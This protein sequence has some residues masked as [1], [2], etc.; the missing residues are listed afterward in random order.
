MKRLETSRMNKNERS[1]SCMSSRKR[2]LTMDENGVE[3]LDVFCPVFPNILECLQSS[4]KSLV[5][6]SET[7]RWLSRCFWALRV[8]WLHQQVCSSG[9]SDP[10]I[11]LIYL[12]T[13]RARVM[14]AR[15]FP[16]S[17]NDY[18]PHA[19]LFL[20][21]P[22][23]SHIFAIFS[24]VYTVTRWLLGCW[25]RPP[26]FS[27]QILKIR[28]LR[29]NGRVSSAQTSS[30]QDD[31]FL[32]YSLVIYISGFSQVRTA[33]THGCSVAGLEPAFLL[34]YSKHRLNDR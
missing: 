8:P 28:I 30:Q 29:R 2:M 17:K 11:R 26:V 21:S 33:A 18:S 1:T 5:L 20:W 3:V 7:R 12:K 23:S 4:R 10:Q 15:W 25:S 22:R 24:N 9:L 14:T 31:V 16:V 27:A 13:S 32:V 6:V 34:K 19:C